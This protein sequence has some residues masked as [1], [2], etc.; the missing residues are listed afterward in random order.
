MTKE[1]AFNHDQSMEV[2]FDVECGSAYL[3]KILIYV[4]AIKDWVEAPKSLNADI[5]KEAEAVVA[6]FMEN[7]ETIINDRL[8]NAAMMECKDYEL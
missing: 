1:S 3:T 6:D 2:E 8:E 4:D 7:F 5:T